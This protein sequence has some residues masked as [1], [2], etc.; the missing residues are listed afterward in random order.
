MYESFPSKRLTEI[1]T[2]ALHRDCNA[3]TLTH[4]QTALL[5]LLAPPENLLMPE[6]AA[7]WALHGT[8]VAMG[9][10]LGLFHDPSGWKLSPQEIKLR[11][12][13]SWAVRCVD[14]WLAAAL[15][16]VPLI[17]E[18]NWMVPPPSVADF[19]EFE[20]ALGV[21]E[22]FIPLVQ[23]TQILISVLAKLL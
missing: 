23:L 6:T 10:G 7:R 15:G 22:V 17:E 19:A 13:L 20:L 2:A 1:A 4:V 3:P 11:R 5:L 8:L 21:S 16:R 9:Q 14:S 18:S 12:I